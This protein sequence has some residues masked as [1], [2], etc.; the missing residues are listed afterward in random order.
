MQTPVTGADT[1]A[2]VS[3]TSALTIE[4]GATGTIVWDIQPTNFTAP[5]QTQSND[6]SYDAAHT[7]FAVWDHVTI[8]QGTTLVW[9]CAPQ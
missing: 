1:Y 3:F 5:N 8:Y 2:E 4:T 6:Y 9:G 7:A